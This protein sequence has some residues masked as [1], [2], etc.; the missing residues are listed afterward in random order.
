MY[1]SKQIGQINPNSPTLTSYGQCW[2]FLPNIDQSGQCW[3]I[4]VN[5]SIIILAFQIYTSKAT[6]FN[7]ALPL[8]RERQ[9]HQQSN[10]YK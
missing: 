9:K 3:R 2:T 4:G 1:K 6:D 8:Q 10:V 7:K 5:I